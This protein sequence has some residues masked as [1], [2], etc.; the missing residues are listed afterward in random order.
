MPLLDAVLRES[1]RMNASETISL[2]C[3]ALQGYTF[4][5]GFSVRKGDIVCT[6]LRAMGHDAS[7][8]D[9]PHLFRPERH[10]TLDSSP[11]HRM[12][13][14]EYTANT[15]H[16]PF[17]GLG[18]EACPGRFYIALVIKSVLAHML[19][20]YEFRLA[21]DKTEP[22]AFTWRTTR[23]PSRRNFLLVRKREI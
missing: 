18:K 17:W 14:T 21:D 6:P 5:D 12:T 16:Y 11:S 7:V 13:G 2:R 4:A 23:I 10:L 1:A 9:Q 3:K 19:H 15:P 22:M 8:V 20:N